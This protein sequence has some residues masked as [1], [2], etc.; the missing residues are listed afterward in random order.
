MRRSQLHDCQ[1]PS[2][3]VD[4]AGYSKNLR[5]VL[6]A[7]RSAAGR[8]IFVTTTPFHRYHNY[9]MACVVQLNA[10]ARQLIAAINAEPAP[11]QG[12]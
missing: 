4:A 5:A 9:S 3:K 6:T 7:A 12:L 10:A 8:V 1:D 11:V 2:G